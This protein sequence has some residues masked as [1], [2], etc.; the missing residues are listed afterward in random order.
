[1]RTLG[2]A[3]KRGTVAVADGVRVGVGVLVVVGVGYQFLRAARPEAVP[4][5]LAFEPGGGKRA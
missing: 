2:V 3:G 1:M 4:S 5:V